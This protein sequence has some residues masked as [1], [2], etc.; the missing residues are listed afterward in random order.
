MAP[1][2]DTLLPFLHL[3]SERE[4]TQTMRDNR[5]NLAVFM[6]PVSP[7]QEHQWQPAADVYKLPQGWLIKFELAGVKL[8]DVTVNVTGRIVRISGRRRDRIEEQG[9]WHYS[10][11]IRYSRFERLVELPEAMEANAIA[12]EMRDGFL[13]VRVSA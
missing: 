3:K 11:E 5:K 13:L 8:E 7:A 10:M 6:V 2:V 4:S 12:L 9:F 1:K